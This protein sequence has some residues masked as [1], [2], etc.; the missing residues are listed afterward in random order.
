[1]RGVAYTYDLTG[2]TRL[3]SCTNRSER[4]Y[5]TAC[6]CETSFGGGNGLQAPG[7]GAMALT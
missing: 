6:G 4:V 7:A 3:I 1:M 5:M 2:L